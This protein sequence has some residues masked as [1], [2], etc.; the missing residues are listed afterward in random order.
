[1]ADEGG[2]VVFLHRIVE[3]GADRSYGVHVA[4]LAGLPRAVVARAQE[5]LRELERQALPAQAGGARGAQLPLLGSPT[6]EGAAPADALFTQLAALDP[7][8]L[9]PLEA[10]QRL[11]ELRREARERL[12]MEG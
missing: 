6:G 2:E 11:Y 4:A 9:S 5:L 12:A 1:M 7:D 10:L 3:G 8:A